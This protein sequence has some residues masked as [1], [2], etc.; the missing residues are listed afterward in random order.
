MKT[1]G[2]LSAPSA[3]ACRAR[4][5]DNGALAVAG[6]A[7]SRGHHRTKHCLLAL[8]DLTG[9]LA[10]RTLIRLRAVPAA[11]SLAGITMV[12]LVNG[13]LAFDAKSR[14]HKIQGH[15]IP[16]IGTAL[17]PASPA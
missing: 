15:A 10:G 6:W 13:Y 7:G 4:I 14:L 16:E 12:F 3:I 5:F 8:V 17:R 11:G 9:S 1:F 2:F